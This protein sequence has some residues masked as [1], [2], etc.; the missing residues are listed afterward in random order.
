MNPFRKGL[1]PKDKIKAEPLK[2][3]IR[4]IDINDKPTHIIR[5]KQCLAAVEW[6]QEFVAGVNDNH[7]DCQFC[8]KIP[9]TVFMHFDLG[10]KDTTVCWKCLPKATWPDLFKAEVSEN[11]GREEEN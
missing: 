3:K 4:L 6:Q 11:D 1:H 5:A 7:F 8:N 9:E 10:G 2:D